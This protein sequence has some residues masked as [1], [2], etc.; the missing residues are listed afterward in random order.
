MDYLVIHDIRELE[1]IKRILIK[2]KSKNKYQNL[3]YILIYKFIK[4]LIL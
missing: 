4:W 3:I 2:L 1:M